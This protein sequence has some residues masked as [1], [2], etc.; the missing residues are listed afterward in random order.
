MNTQVGESIGTDLEFYEYGSNT[1]SIMLRAKFQVAMNTS[2]S[3]M[4]VVFIGFQGWHGSQDNEQ[5]K[6]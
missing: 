3:S 1:V 6:C 2:I 4:C 5:M